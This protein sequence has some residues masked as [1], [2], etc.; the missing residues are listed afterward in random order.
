M[1]GLT[2]ACQDMHAHVG[3]RRPRQVSPDLGAFPDACSVRLRQL[4]DVEC[5]AL[6]DEVH[7]MNLI[8]DVLVA[9]SSNE[10]TVR[11]RATPCEWELAPGATCARVPSS[12]AHGG[13]PQPHARTVSCKL[14]THFRPRSTSLLLV[15]RTTPPH[16]SAGIRLTPASTTSTHT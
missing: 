16:P 6:V 5:G 8:L 12:S 15:V 9:A 1:P 13:S 7:P 3:I 10:V 14:S 11:L 2:M 4:A